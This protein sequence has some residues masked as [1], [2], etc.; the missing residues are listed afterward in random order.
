ML[1]QLSYRGSAA[2]SVA[3]SGE[4]SD[5]VAELRELLLQLDET[6]TEQ[7]LLRLRERRLQRQLA[8]ADDANLIELQQA[9]GEI[10]EAIR[11]A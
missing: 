10:R 7:L 8:E 6:T 1:C 2:P 9:L 11:S 5:L 3:A 4:G